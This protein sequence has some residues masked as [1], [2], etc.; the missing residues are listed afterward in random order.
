MSGRLKTAL[1][2]RRNGRR[3]EALKIFRDLARKYPNDPI[4]RF[5]LA[6]TLDNMGRESQAIPHYHR[7]LRLDRNH[8]ARYEIMLYLASSYRKTARPAAARR[9]LARA[10]AMKRS[11]P[12]QEKLRRLL[13]RT[14]R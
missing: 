14:K 9:W 8:P 12:L 3:R 6:Q 4:L 5:E 2:L 1:R 10:E 13:E 11:S 7:A